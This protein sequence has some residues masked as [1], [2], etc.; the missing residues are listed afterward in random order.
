MEMSVETE[1]LQGVSMQGFFTQNIVPAGDFKQEF[2]KS[3]KNFCLQFRALHSG[4]FL[5]VLT[6]KVDFNG[7]AQFQMQ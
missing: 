5:R 3:G 6:K 7:E 1:L 4:S 2:R